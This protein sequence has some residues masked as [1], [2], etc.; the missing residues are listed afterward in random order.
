MLHIENVSNR[1]QSTVKNFF[2]LSER[3]KWNARAGFAI[4][5]DSLCKF[6]S[7]YEGRVTINTFASYISA[8]KAYHISNNVQ[9]NIPSTLVYRNYI[10][11]IKFKL[12]EITNQD[13]S[14]TLEDLHK[15]LKTLNNR[16]HNDL[17]AGC[18]A[19]CLFFGIT[20]CSEIFPPK[21]ASTT[22]S[23]VLHFD[24][25]NYCIRLLNPKIKKSYHQ[26]L[27][28]MRWKIF[29]NPQYWLRL[30]IASPCKFDFLWTL[31]SGKMATSLWFRTL[32]SQS[33]NTPKLVGECSFRAGGTSF[34][35]KEGIPPEHIRVLGRW[36]SDA[37]TRYIRSHPQILQSVLSQARLRH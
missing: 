29:V 12:S 30:L 24:G 28:P 9:W 15:F 34:L 26:Y 1:Y 37:W 32:F 8:L 13:Y 22:C 33:T 18:I 5:V 20:R 25:S 4:D 19:T 6:A 31:D 7:H 2:R 14:V 35:L 36:D 10:K 27:V 23:Q 11:A 17:V 16:E 21:D 3:K